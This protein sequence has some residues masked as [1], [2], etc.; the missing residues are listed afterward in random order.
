MVTAMRYQELNSGVHH[1]TFEA[2]G[3]AAVDA[4]A[5]QIEQLQLAGKWYGLPLVRMVIDARKTPQIPI[6]YFFE[7]LSDYNREYPGLKPPS[8]QIAFIHDPN[9]V[10]LSIFHSF[11]ELM[12]TPVEARY[13][14]SHQ[15]DAA[16]KWLS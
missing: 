1:F 13:F 14:P 9:T 8:L 7:C 5:H 15:D 3:H 11:A 6:R 4:W 16:L 2:D 10:V 12:S